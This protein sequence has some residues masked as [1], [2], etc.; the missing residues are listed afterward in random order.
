MT[1]RI[2]GSALELASDAE[3]RAR[4]AQVEA[5]HVR[6]EPDG[7]RDG[8]VHVITGA[9]QH[10]KTT[11]AAQWLADA[12]E[13]VAR[14]LLV[15]S[16]IVASEVRHVLGLPTRDRSVRSWRRFLDGHEHL[17]PGVEY[18]ID[19]VTQFAAAAL[20]TREL[21]HMLTVGTATD[22]QVR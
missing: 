19:D 12:P 16:E 1:D 8:A 5:A 22:A 14:V 7:W 3:R 18:G 17:R 15:D 20:R 13:G 21:P 9:R 10:G 6:M 2:L 11:M 4:I